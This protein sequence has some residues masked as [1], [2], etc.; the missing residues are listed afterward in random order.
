MCLDQVQ[1]CIMTIVW[2]KEHFKR[3]IVGLL[4]VPFKASKTI[5][6]VFL[7]RKRIEIAE[8]S[9]GKATSSIA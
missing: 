9:L 3:K 2:G 6:P 5:W 7:S 1:G 4:V 8:G